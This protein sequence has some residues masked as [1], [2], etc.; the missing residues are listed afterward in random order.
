MAENV[1]NSTESVLAL[2]SVEEATT[3][4]PL[5]EGQVSL[6]DKLGPLVVQVGN[7]AWFRVYGVIFPN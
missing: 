1:E 6:V 5:N 4:I 7:V 3:S 2:P